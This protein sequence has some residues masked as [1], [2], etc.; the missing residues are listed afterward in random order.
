MRGEFDVLRRYWRDEQGAI[1]VLAAFVLVAVVGGIGIGARIRPCAVAKGREPARSRSR[2]LWRCPRLTFDWLDRQRHQCC[3]QHRGAE[4]AV[5][6][7]HPDL[8][9]FAQRRRQSRDQGYSHDQSAAG[10]G[11]GALMRITTL[12]VSATAYAEINSSAP[13]CIIALSSSPATCGG[14]PVGSACAAALR[15]RL[16]IAPWPRQGRRRLTRPATGSPPPPSTITRPPRRPW[17]ARSI[18]RAVAR[19]PLTKSLLRTR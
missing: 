3:Q 13:A 7:R 19:R 11:R 14:S 5:E 9:S 12:P 6:R 16:R 15:Y 10:A 18:N 1:S 8:C 4:R 17:P 2:L